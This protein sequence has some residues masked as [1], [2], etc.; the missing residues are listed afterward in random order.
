MSKVGDRVLEVPK[1]DASGKPWPL[2]KKRLEVSLTAR[3]LIG[4]LY[5]TKKAPVNPADGKAVAWIP[6][7]PEELQAVEDYE[8]ALGKWVEEDAIVQQQIAVTIPDSIF[9]DLMSKQTAHEYFEVLCKKFGNRSL[10]IGVET[11]CQ[12]GE[13]KLRRR[14]CAGP[15][16]ESKTPSRRACICW[17][18]H[19]GHRPPSRQTCDGKTARCQVPNSLRWSLTHTTNSSCRVVSSQEI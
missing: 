15:F 14:R 11:R 8:I 3:G 9:I 7:K 13:L 2:W 5:G 18:P 16:R 12:L 17:A 4:Y 19:L 6:V 10:V 1:L